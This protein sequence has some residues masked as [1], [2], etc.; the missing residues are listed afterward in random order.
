MAV[1]VVQAAAAHRPDLIDAIGE[2]EA[3]I[4]HVHAGLRERDE[5]AVHIGDP[6][7]Q[8]STSSRARAPPNPSDFSLRCRA[9]RSMP[10]NAAVREILPPKRMIWASR[11]SRSNSSRAS[12]SG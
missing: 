9:E 7:H 4:L 5:A 12:R 6:R 8:S 3:A 2:L 11:Y 1:G 10:M